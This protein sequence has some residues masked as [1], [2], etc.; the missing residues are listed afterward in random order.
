MCVVD[1]EGR[2]VCN[3]GKSRNDEAD[4]IRPYSGPLRNA[5]ESPWHSYARPMR[6]ILSH[7]GQHTC[8]LFPGAM[9]AITPTTIMPRPFALLCLLWEQIAIENQ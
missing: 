2:E 9:A 8:V 6:C 3:E 4:I 7:S 1:G 5:R